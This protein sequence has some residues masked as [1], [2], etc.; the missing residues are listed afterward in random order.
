MMLQKNTDYTL[1]KGN[2]STLSLI[3]LIRSI[4]DHSCR[5]ALHEFHSNRTIFYLNGAD[6]M[7]FVDYLIK[8]REKSLPPA[9]RT[10]QSL[11][12]ADKAYDITLDKFSRLPASA[13]TSEPEQGID[14]RFYFQAFLEH[15]ESLLIS[16]HPA[17]GF[18]QEIIAAHA[19]QNFVRRH[20][21]FSFI[22]A[23]R[24]NSRF[25]TRYNWNIC[26][27]TLCIWLPIYI[28]GLNR[29]KWLER[30]IDD[31]DP[32]RPGER[33]RIQKIVDKKL[34]KPSL[35][36][37]DEKSKVA[38]DNVPPLWDT[39]YE[40]ED[41]LLGTVVA[42][43]KADNIEKQRRSIQRLGP[44]KLKQMI[45]RIFTDISSD[46][47]NVGKIAR[48]YG[49]S[50][51]TFSRFAGSKWQNNKKVPDLWQNTAQVL[52]THPVF[53]EVLKISGMLK[54]IKDNF[55]INEAPKDS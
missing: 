23:E 26:G 55:G 12:L 5:Q 9:Q 27:H 42:R 38:T 24:Q 52:L 30:N 40:N 22:E 19:L 16:K 15:A 48:D 41:L 46:N 50:K 13:N 1:N 18:E 36:Y 17:D 49:L 7:L 31:P 33:Q 53:K 14:C 21:Y 8:L 29:R 32:A 3:E 6:P 11:E 47:Y 10:I 39:D 28:S 37:I 4:T 43:E 45:K 35:L 2:K 51:S 20:Y 34:A 25:W 54:H 44:E